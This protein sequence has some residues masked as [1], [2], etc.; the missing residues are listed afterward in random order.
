MSDRVIIHMD[1]NSYFARLTQSLWENP[2][3]VYQE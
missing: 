1:M 3:F 2:L